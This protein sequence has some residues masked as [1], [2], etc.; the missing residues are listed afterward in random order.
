MG[1]PDKPKTIGEHLKKRRIE[2]RLK[3]TKVASLLGVH[4]GS[5]QL[6]EQGRGE[7][8]VRSFP[9]IIRFLG[10]VPFECNGTPGGRFAFLRRCSGKTQEELAAL[11]GCNPSSIG[12]WESGLPGNPTKSDAAIAQIWA[13][14]ERFGIDQTVSRAFTL[15]D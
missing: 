9:A 8:G 10:Y 15:A 5:I 7:Q 6:W 2:L 3:Q 4:R 13:E 14:L 12:R 11:A 1:C